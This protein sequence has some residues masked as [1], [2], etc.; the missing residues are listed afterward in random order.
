[1]TFVV[2]A[3]DRVSRSGLAV[4]EADDRFEVRR[5]A[6]SSSPGFT[7][8][9]SSAHALI[10]RSATKVDRALM[11]SARTL[12]VIGRA[13]VGVDNIDVPAATR[14][15]I[16]VFNAPSGNTVAAA[17]L[18]LAL[19]LSVARMIPTAD[20]SVREGVWDRARFQGF[21]LRGRVLGL[22]GAG[23]VGGEVASRA[24]AFGMTV[25]AYDPYLAPERAAELGIELVSLEHLLA[26]SDVVSLHTPLNDETRGLLGADA[27]GG[28]K[29]GAIV[30]NASR[31]GVIDEAALAAALEEG[32]IGGAAVDVYAVEP[33]PG[34][35]PLL[36]APNLVMTPHL[37]ASTHEAQV[38]VA[39]E[40]AVAIRAALV[41]GDLR[42]AVNAADLA[43]RPG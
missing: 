17:E 21:E 15:G 35:S 19:M 29:K 16:A 11:E 6:D 1:V 22:I 23:R 39:H 24:L 42:G 18:T 2:L 43:A 26:D 32:V 20:R 4:L 37:G 36:G 33:L 14:R 30:V 8:A 31:G 5:Q 25:V 7:E 38:G 41:E 3:A 12:A 9:L 10:V 40:V 34:D 27:L 13:G 28:M